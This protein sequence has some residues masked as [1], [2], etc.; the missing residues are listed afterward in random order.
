MNA[1]SRPIGVLDDAKRFGSFRRKLTRRFASLTGEKAD[2]WDFSDNV[3]DLVTRKLFQ[4]PAMM[5]PALQR[6]LVAAILKIRPS[7]KTISDPFVGSGTILVLTMLNG[8]A[9]LGQDINPLAI[10]LAKVRAYSLNYHELSAGVKHIIVATAAVR[11]TVPEVRFVGQSKWFT[12]GA[13]LGLTKIRA[14]IRDQSSVD[15]R[16]FLWVCLA[17]CIRL[18]SNSRTSTFKLHVKPSTERTASEQSV[19]RSF[20]AIAT[21][22]LHVVKEFVS[23]LRRGGH[24]D[25][26][27]KY[28]LPIRIVYGNTMNNIAGPTWERDGKCSLVVTSPPYGDNRTTVPYGQAAWL[29]LQWIDMT[30]IDQSIPKDAARSAYAVDNRSIGGY[31]NRTTFRVRMEQ[32]INHG[33]VEANY[34]AQ[35]R[36][37]AGDGLS[38][39]VHFAYDLEACLENVAENC[40]KGGN[41]VLT[42]GHR[43]IGGTICPLTDLCQ[44]ILARCDLT[45]VLRVDRHIR[46]KRMAAKNKHSAT[47]NHEYIS[48]LRKASSFPRK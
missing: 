19:I 25:S 3:E 48:I 4:Y 16:R 34:I 28:A 31:R 29:P 11:R 38:R 37:R 14:L 32:L 1:Q 46:S 20:A 15:V 36:G 6:E 26:D 2:F 27:G 42:L 21:R 33:G 17:E 30:D 22:N 43:N 10:L 44:Q 12:P 45:E 24:L 39:F 13:S 9:F 40:R 18:N 23:A 47:I 5:V 35:L 8:R 7:V 41:V